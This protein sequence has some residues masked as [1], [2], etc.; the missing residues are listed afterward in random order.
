MNVLDNGI[1]I[2]NAISQVYLLLLKAVEIKSYTIWC[3]DGTNVNHQLNLVYDEESDTYSL[4]DVMGV[5]VGRGNK[6]DFFGYNI[7]DANKLGEGSKNLVDF[8]CPW[9]IAPMEYLEY[10]IDLPLEERC[11]PYDDELS[12]V[13]PKIKSVNY[14]FTK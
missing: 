4:D 2:C 1:G 11:E 12:Q 5:I 3:D 9:E 7:E 8:D 10:I 6:D 14:G 13:L